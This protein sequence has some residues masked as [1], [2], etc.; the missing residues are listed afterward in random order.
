MNI[1]EGLNDEV[2]MLVLTNRRDF[3]SLKEKG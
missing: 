3:L 2:V 1:E